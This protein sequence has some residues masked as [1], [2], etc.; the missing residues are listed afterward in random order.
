MGRLG[1][2]E[3]HSSIHSVS[4]N[5]KRL[6]VKVINKLNRNLL[7]LWVSKSTQTSDQ[8]KRINTGCGIKQR[9][10][11]AILQ[12]VINAGFS[13]MHSAFQNTETLELL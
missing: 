9:Q 5:R 6:I 13:A 2:K 11:E 12:N 3:Q 4:A 7:V 1:G 8:E 10:G